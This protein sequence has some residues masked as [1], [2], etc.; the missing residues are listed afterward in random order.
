MKTFLQ[1]REASK[2]V[3]PP[4]EHVFDAKI[5]KHK[6]M[7]HKDKNKYVAYIDLEKFDSFNSLND[8]KKAATQFIKIAGGK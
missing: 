1:I 4:G 8:A 7:I 6:V 5:D 3:M 2:S